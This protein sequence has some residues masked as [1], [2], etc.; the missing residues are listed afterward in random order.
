MGSTRQQRREVYYS[1]H[2]QGVGFRYTTQQIA[3][4][5]DVTG[6]VQNLSDGRVQLVVESETAE[7]KRFLNE[8][9][10]RLGEYINDVKVTELAPS[11]EFTGFSIRH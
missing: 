3:R 4:G 2:V 10:D 5:F 8:I 11:G 1:G 9:A 7:M 6:F